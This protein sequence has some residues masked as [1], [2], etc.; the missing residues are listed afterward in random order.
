MAV[1]IG[2]RRVLARHQGEQTGEDD[3]FQQVGVVAGVVGV[4]IVH[5]R[6]GSLGRE[7]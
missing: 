3:V 2:E 1:E 6:A 5:G 4:A 7:V